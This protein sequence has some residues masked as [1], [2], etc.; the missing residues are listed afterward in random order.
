MMNRKECIGTISDHFRNKSVE[1]IVELDLM[2]NYIFLLRLFLCSHCPKEVY[3][4]PNLSYRAP[5]V[6][7]QAVVVASN[8]TDDRLSPT[9]SLYLVWFQMS[10]PGQNL[11]QFSSSRSTRVKVTCYDNKRQKNTGFDTNCYD[12][13]R[14][15]V[16]CILHSTL[17]M[18][19]FYTHQTNCTLLYQPI[20]EYAQL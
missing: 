1:G 8:Y 10:S 16:I 14:N 9:S 19:Y 6:F 12:V 3:T 11:Q 5:K 7:M 2:R 4:S 17:S 15:A 13:I 18:A 20:H